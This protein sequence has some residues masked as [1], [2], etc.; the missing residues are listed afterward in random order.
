[1][2]PSQQVV[3]LGYGLDTVSQKIFLS[4]DKGEKLSSEVQRLIVAPTVSLRMIMLVLGLMTSAIPAVVWA[5]AHIRS[6]H[7]F[8]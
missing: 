8:C 3:F 6:L 2:I 5:Q 4:K 7:S 1:M